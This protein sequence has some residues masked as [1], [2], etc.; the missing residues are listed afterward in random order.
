MLRAE[1]VGLLEEGVCFGEGGCGLEC[2][3]DGAG[4][5]QGLG[6]VG[7]L[8]EGELA[9]ALAEEREG[10]LGNHAE[11]LPALGG[12]AVALRCCLLVASGFVEGGR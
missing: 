1:R 3:E 7:V 8:A 11:R 12:P 9:A 4:L 6:R 10:L 5:L 2:Q